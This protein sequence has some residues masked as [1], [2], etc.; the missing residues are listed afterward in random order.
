MKIYILNYKRTPINSYLSSYSN[1]NALNL[2]TENLKHL[3]ETLDFSS[4]L[5]ENAYLGNVLSAGNGQNIARQITY[6][7]GLNIPSFTINS[8][9]GSGLQSIIEGFK[10]IKLGE[11]KCCLVGGV[12]S[13]THTPYLQSNIKKGN[14]YGNLELVDSMMVDGLVDSFSNQHMGKITEM[15]ATRENINKEV[16][17]KYAVNSYLKARKAWEEQ[18]FSH[19]VIKTNLEEDEEVNKV[20]DLDK[21]FKLK[22]FFMKDGSITAGNASKLSD[23]S[24]MLI[25]ANEE[26]VKNNNLT[27]LVEI[28][29]YDISVGDPD[30]FALMPIKSI[31]KLIAKQSLNL[32]EIDAFEINEAFSLVPIMVNKK[33]GIPYDKI[34]M[35]GGA[36]SMGHP[37]GCSGS[38]ITSTLISIL[39][40]EKKKIG[41]V[42]ICNGG[43]GA[44]SML[45]KNV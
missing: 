33:L 14:K 28:L 5:I 7:C 10:S 45:I 37:L 16:Q 20:K 24:S 17:D 25:L 30:Q 19:E 8:V 32:T 27:P 44:T 23:G 21:I 12:E 42:S 31:S 1:H 11:S 18:K 40:N 35:Y 36:V 41:C 29:D 9:C 13:M 2:G 39:K 26:F 15:I 34:N 22:P 3:L 38:R 4:D 6:S 43:G